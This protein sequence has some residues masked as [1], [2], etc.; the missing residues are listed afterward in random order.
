M[1]AHDFRQFLDRFHDLNPAQIEDARTKIRDVRR[2]TE[3]LAEIE[4][5]TEQEHKCPHCGDDRRQKWGRTRTKV[6]R[7]RCLGCQKTFCGRTTSRIRHIHRPDLFLE[8]IQDMLGT[9]APSSIRQLANRLGLDKHTIWRWRLIIMECLAGSSSDQFAGIVEA[10]EAFQRESRK[11]SREWVRYKRD[12]K[13]NPKPPRLR[14]YEYGKKGVKMLRGLSRWQLPILTV[15]DRSGSKMVQRIP[16]RHNATI[17]NALASVVPPDAVLCS[18]A[19]QAYRSFAQA[20]GMEHF[21]VG[22]AKGKAKATASHHIQNIN[23]LH[24]RYEDFI[25]QFKGPASKYLRGYL[26]WFAARM[27]RLGYQPVYAAI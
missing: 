12:P 27:H 24:S 1:Q 6:Q 21:V 9:R 7:Y 5:R 17:S 19:H 26:D 4:S 23:S 20:A 11:G 10:D 15:V 18:D 25:R 2:K 16:N 22:G 14:W 3:A 8:V 13:N